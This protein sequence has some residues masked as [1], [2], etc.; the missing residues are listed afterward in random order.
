MARGRWRGSFK[1]V[2]MLRRTPIKKV[3]KKAAQRRREWKATFATAMKLSN[4]RCIIQ[5]E[6]ICLGYATQGHH[7]KARSQGGKNELA[8]CVP[9]CAACHRHV[10]ANPKWAKE[11]GWIA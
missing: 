6:G 11:H 9:A 1:G 7:R 10:H 4:H 8:N 3:S 5:V 2:D